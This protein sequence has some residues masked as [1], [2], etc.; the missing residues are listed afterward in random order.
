M[1]FTRV[2]IA[3]GSPR[4]TPNGAGRQIQDA[5]S[6]AADSVAADNPNAFDSEVVRPSI[7]SGMKEPRNLPGLKVDSGQVRALV[8]V[9]AVAGKRQVVWIVG[10]AVLLRDDVLHVMLQL[11][12]LLA[13]AAVFATLAGPAAH[14]LARCLIQV[15]LN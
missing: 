15:L 12:M 11:G 3:S 6:G 1:E 10:A 2:D 14:E 8:E 5:G 9:A 4:A 7:L 13:Q